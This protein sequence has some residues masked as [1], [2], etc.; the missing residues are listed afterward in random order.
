MSKRSN[1]LSE[2]NAKRDFAKTPEPSGKT[3]SSESGN[4]FIV[5]KHDAT[6]LHWDLRLEVDAA[7]VAGKLL[8]VL[9]RLLG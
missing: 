5:Q 8:G 3:Q 1:T 7:F 4:L 9:R 2:Y 6:R